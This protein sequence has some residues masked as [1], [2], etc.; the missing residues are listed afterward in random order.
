MFSSTTSIGDISSGQWT[1]SKPSVE[2]W[3]WASDPHQCLSYLLKAN[4]SNIEGAEGGQEYPWTSEQQQ[5]KDAQHLFTV[6]C[7]SVMALAITGTKSLVTASTFQPCPVWGPFIPQTPQSWWVIIKLW[8]GAHCYYLFKCTL[9]QA[10][11]KQSIP[12]AV[13]LPQ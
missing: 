8:Y 7:C 3:N 1:W 2:M 12:R 13:S 11:E 4:L 9:C 10:G 5:S 6:V